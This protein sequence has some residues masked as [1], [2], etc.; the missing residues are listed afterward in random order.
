[1]TYSNGSHDVVRDQS[2]TDVRLTTERKAQL[3]ALVE[4]DRDMTIDEAM[5]VA[6]AY[7]AMAQ[8]KHR[9]RSARRAV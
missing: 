6:G 8:R 7:E 1:M 5:Y 9:Q 4:L 3:V 2:P